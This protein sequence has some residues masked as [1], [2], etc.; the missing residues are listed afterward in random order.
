MYLHSASIYYSRYIQIAAECTARTLQDA[1]L[2]R[3][4]KDTSIDHSTVSTAN[5]HPVALN[6]SIVCTMLHTSKEMYNISGNEN[7]SQYG[8]FPFIYIRVI[9]STLLSS[10]SAPY[11]HWIIIIAVLH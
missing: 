1:P 5:C 7:R 10:E 4:M 11:V 6:T 3:V 8:D 9:G 2:T